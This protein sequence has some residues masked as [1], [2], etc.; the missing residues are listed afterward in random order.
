MTYVNF[1]KDLLKF[2]FL[3]YYALRATE[4][5]F[6]GGGGVVIT[7]SLEQINN[8]SGDFY[9]SYQLYS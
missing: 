7:I 4:W 9:L 1:S 2:F 3:Y 8:V 6:N 5:Q